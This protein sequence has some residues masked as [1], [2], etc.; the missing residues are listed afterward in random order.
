MFQG[1]WQAFNYVTKYALYFIVVVQSLMTCNILI[2]DSSSENK[3]SS[4]D[5]QH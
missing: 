5:G 4:A 1:L 3:K 2:D